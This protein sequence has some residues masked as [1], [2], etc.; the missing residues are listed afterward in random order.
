VDDVARRTRMGM[1]P[2]GG[3]RC[4]LRCGAI[5]ADELGLDPREGL[6]QAAS[7]LSRM[8]RSRLPGLGPVQARQEAL[9][10]ALL[11]SQAGIHP[12]GRS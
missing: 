9:A 10:I 12:G 2:C 8:A 7:F 1:G 11:R 5:V 6:R 3:M 4:A